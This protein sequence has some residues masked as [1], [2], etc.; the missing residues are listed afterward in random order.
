MSNDRNYRA[1]TTEALFLLSRGHCYHPDCKHRV[2]AWNG[3][4]WRKNVQVAHIRGLPGG[5]RH[6]ESKSDKVNHFSNL[7]LMCKVHH[8]LVDKKPTGD[9]YSA[10]LL[11]EWKTQREG[12]LADQ[13]D[14]LDWITEDKLQEFMARAIHDTHSKIDE[15]ITKVSGVSN[16]T[17]DLLKRLAFE[18][19]QRPYLD[20]DAVESLERSATTLLEITD[21]IPTLERSATNLR[22]LPDHSSMLYRAAHELRDIGDYASTLIHAAD[23]LAHLERQAPMFIDAADIL[24]N[25]STRMDEFNTAVGRLSDMRFDE[26]VRESDATKEAAR[27]LKE[28]HAS[29]ANEDRA[30]IERVAQ[31]LAIASQKPP[32][33]G[34]SWR[35]FG[36]GMGACFIAVVTI[37][38]LWTNATAR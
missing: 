28:A 25:S 22:E 18:S 3:N 11:I 35:A 16:E 4:E 34:W 24:A 1:G 17:L 6:D 8:D 36:I 13:L 12:H 38:I 33:A 30:A 27:Q 9:N 21:Y 26:L 32:R 2:M 23:L 37:L 20:T 31:N 7:L 15:A 5:P 19:F 10:E 14:Q 29:W